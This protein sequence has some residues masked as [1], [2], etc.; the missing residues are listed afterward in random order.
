[1]IS[2]SCCYQLLMDKLLIDRAA[3]MLIPLVFLSGSSG[4]SGLV[5]I[6]LLA[7]LSYTPHLG[8]H[9]RIPEHFLSYV[10]I[11]IVQASRHSVLAVILC[12][13]IAESF[14]FFCTLTG[15]GGRDLAFDRSR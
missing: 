10:D 3:F 1:M 5:Y 12:F 6:L 13:H 11:D 7:R 9:K 15:C 4:F 2:G 8:F 14:S